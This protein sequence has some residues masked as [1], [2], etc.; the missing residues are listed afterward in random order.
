VFGRI[1]WMAAPPLL[2]PHPAA[3]RRWIDV[4][5]LLQCVLQRRGVVGCANL[6]VKMHLRAELHLTLPTWR[7]RMD[8]YVV[9]AYGS[10]TGW[11]WDV[12]VPSSPRGSRLNVGWKARSLPVFHNDAADIIAR[13]R[14]QYRLTVVVCRSNSTTVDAV[15]LAHRYLDCSQVNVVLCGGRCASAPGIV[16][17]KSIN[18]VRY[19]LF[20]G[21]VAVVYGAR[22]AF[23]AVKQVVAAE[24]P[25]A[26]S[27][28]DYYDL[29]DSM[30]LT[31]MQLV[32]AN[33]ST[34]AHD[35]FRDYRPF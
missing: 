15:R 16:T 19:A 31:R 3:T 18:G 32:R 8:A 28:A 9:P 26:V 25:F 7:R 27:K 6:A 10:C 23:H 11:P 33:T 14:R 22:D 21:V 1:L 12:C 5:V 24:L 17:R 30:S 29:P 13:S 34:K 35:L 4:V 2:V 20:G